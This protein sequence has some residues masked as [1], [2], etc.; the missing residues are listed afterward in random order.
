MKRRSSYISLL[1]TLILAVVQPVDLEAKSSF[2]AGL[3]TD[4]GLESSPMM[5]LTHTGYLRFRSDLFINPHMGIIHPT[6]GAPIGGMRKPVDG[7]SYSSTNI[8][9]RWNPTLNI[10]QAFKVHTVIDALDNVVLGS[11]PDS[12]ASRPDSPFA[13]SADSQDP[14]AEEDAIRVKQVWGEWN[15]GHSF[16]LKLGRMGDH[17]GLGMVHNDG[18]CEDCDFGDLTD[19]VS[20]FFKISGFNSLWFFDS[21][22][23]GH[24]GQLPGA[25]GQASDLANEDDVYRWGFTVGSQPMDVTSRAK[26]RRELARGK[27]VVD[28]GVRNDF[29]TQDFHTDVQST[30]TASCA[31]TAGQTVD[32]D[33]VKLQSREA[34]LWLPNLWVKLQ[35]KPHYNTYFRAEFEAA[36]TLGDVK[37]TQNLKSP[38]SAKEF[39]GFGGAAELEFTTG[40]LTMLLHT[41]LA[42]G[43]ETAFGSFGPGFHEPNDSLYGQNQTVQDNTTVERFLFNRDYHVD[44]LL[45]RQQIGTITNSFYVKPAVRAYLLKSEEQEMGMEVGALYGH[46]LKPES[47]PGKDSPLGIEGNVRLF[48]RQPKTFS[49]DLEGAVLMPLGAFNAPITGKSPELTYTIQGRLTARF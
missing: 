18:R 6:T 38:S 32:A 17:W 4:E 36:A 7:N 2:K 23:E 28:W 11:S 39:V 14:T 34:N 35:W 9:F 49:A 15:I 20:M 45:F 43:D 44:M 13:F 26:R 41:G 27:V 47:T 8:R 21:P 48:F 30:T 33:C 12:G 5:T 1:L 3:N 42:T 40:K 25:Y 19:R 10:G 31:S 22:A 37:Y 46:A 16:L 29:I 24:I